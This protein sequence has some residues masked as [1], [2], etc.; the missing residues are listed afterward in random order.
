VIVADLVQS[1]I[2]SPS[3]GQGTK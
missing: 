3:G 1:A 2:R